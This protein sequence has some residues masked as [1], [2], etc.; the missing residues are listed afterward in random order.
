MYIAV[1]N[2][3]GYN[4]FSPG[5]QGA[6]ELNR[7]VIDIAQRNVNS[8]FDLAKSL[9]GARTVHEAVDLQ[10]ARDPVRSGRRTARLVEKGCRRH[11]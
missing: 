4:R 3:M 6:M 8:G 7:K 9:A 11:A 2:K 1:H 5:F 10:T